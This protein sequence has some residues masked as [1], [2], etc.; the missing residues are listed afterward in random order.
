MDADSTAVVS[1]K[2][3]NVTDIL[4]GSSYM[5]YSSSD[6]DGSATYYLNGATSSKTASLNKGDVVYAYEN[7]D[8]DVDRV[9]VA[10][11]SYARI[12]SVSDNMSTTEKDNGAA[13]RLKLVDIDDNNIG[14]YYDAY[15]GSNKNGL[16][17]FDASIY[18]EGTVPAVAMNGKKAV[19]S[20]V[21]DV[22]TETP[23]FVKEAINGN[24]TIGGAKYN[25]AGEPA[26]NY[27]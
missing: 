10:R 19:A 22:V 5:D 24:I 21:A 2:D 11:Y 12:D 1:D 26:D 23:T 13:Y 4:T 16:P 20:Y 25:Y 9:V 17:G 18:E 3:K 15:D 27:C 14:T 8:G 7:G 6:I